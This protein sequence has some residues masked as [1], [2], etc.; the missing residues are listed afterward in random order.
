MDK[1]KRDKKFSLCWIDKQSGQKFPAGIA[2]YHEDK[3]DFRLKVDVLPDEKLVYLR[4]I[5]SENNEVQYRID[6]LLKRNG[7]FMR[8]APIGTGYSNSQTGNYIFMDLGP[9]S[10]S[11]ALDMGA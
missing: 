4:P 2:F 8:A 6:V 9:F 7:Q 10:R 1:E 11:L 3:G 5:R